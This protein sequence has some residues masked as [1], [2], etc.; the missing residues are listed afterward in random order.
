MSK[1]YKADF[2]SAFQKDRVNYILYIPTFFCAKKEITSDYIKHQVK[3]IL[4]TF[5][6]Q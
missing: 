3:K 2:T 1:H 4:G 6:T 5:I